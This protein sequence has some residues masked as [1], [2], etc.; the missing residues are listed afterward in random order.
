MKIL[1]INTAAGRGVAG[2]VPDSIQEMGRSLG[3]EML[4]AVGRGNSAGGRTTL[5][6]AFSTGVHW[7]AT[8]LCDR[9]GLHSRAATRRLWQ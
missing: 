6:D 2:G 3:H 9:H 7:A 1:Q 4:M 5:A 8:R